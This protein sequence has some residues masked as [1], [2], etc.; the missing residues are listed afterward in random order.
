MKNK[1]GAFYEGW[2]NYV[3]S[4]PE[5]EVLSKKRLD[6]CKKCDHYTTKGRCRKCGCIMAAKTRSKRTKCPI[7]LW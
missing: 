7:K 4:D 6:I 5:I 2:K 1:I 3:I